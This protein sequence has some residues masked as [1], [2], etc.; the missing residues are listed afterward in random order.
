MGQTLRMISQSVFHPWEAPFPEVEVVLGSLVFSA[1]TASSALEMRELGRGC[2]RAAAH[3]LSGG[4]T[5]EL[6]Y[7]QL[8]APLWIGGGQ[9]IH[10]SISHT[11]QCA[12]GVA[13]NASIG[14]DIEL[15]DRDV[16]RL[17]K[18]FTPGEQELAQALRPIALLCAKEAAGKA[19]G[20]GLAG[21]INRWNVIAFAVDTQSL[22]VKDL[23][24][25]DQWRVWIG[26][27]EIDGRSLQCA[28][29]QSAVHI[30]EE[31]QEIY[32]TAHVEMRPIGSQSWQEATEAVRERAL[33]GVVITAWNPGVDR[34]TVAEN[35]Q[36]NVLLLERLK[37]YCSDIW[38][39]DGFAPDRVHREPG[40]IAW[41][42]PPEVGLRIAREFDQFAIFYF[43]AN[44][45]RVLMSV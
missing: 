10:V 39:A 8:G 24:T 26:V 43:D 36:A 34:P 31:L 9:Q 45:T 38:E 33:S 27:V 12:V 20:V 14:V 3:K 44:G 2:A 6:I 15:L 40:F 16:S 37:Q 7:S 22:L 35:E 1:E 18:S 28:I 4:L 25:H 32:E 29:A 23:L 30:R 19:T 21:S 11:G 17:V 42:M 5:G 41:G 13:A